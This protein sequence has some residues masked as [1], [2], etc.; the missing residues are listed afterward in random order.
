MRW[1]EFFV[2]KT[3]TSPF[4]SVSARI[5]FSSSPGKN[6]LRA[7]IR[8]RFN[9]LECSFFF[10]EIGAFSF[11]CC[12][13][14]SPIKR[15]ARERAAARRVG[16]R[17]NARVSSDSPWI[18]LIVL[19]PQCSWFRGVPR[20]VRQSIKCPIKCPCVKGKPLKDCVEDVEPVIPM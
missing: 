14:K 12:L 15:P 17:D 13:A 16:K 20:I 11:A 2:T 5:A 3:E 6:C 18:W 8:L 7:V 10:G 1:M 19:L 4:A 9:V